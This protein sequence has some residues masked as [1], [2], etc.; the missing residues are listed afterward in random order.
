[1]IDILAIDHLVLRTCNPQKLID[2]YCQVLGC[3]IE[4]KTEPE[5]GLTQLR[6]GSAL[7]DIVNVRSELGKIGGAAPAKSGNNLDHFCLL[8]NKISED[9]LVAHLS[10]Y[11]VKY[12]DFAQRY[13]SQ[14]FGSSIYIED[15]DGN[16]IELKSTL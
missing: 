8:V 14:G 15:P 13:G 9:T 1:M 16:I 5:L 4:R 3:T 6:A 7:I 12:G 11:K 10:H 2:F